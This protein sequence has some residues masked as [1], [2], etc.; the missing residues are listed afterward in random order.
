M[1]E[2]KNLFGE[3]INPAEILADDV[4][5]DKQ[6]SVEYE[7]RFNQII[8]KDFTEAD[9]NIFFILCAVAKIK[10]QGLSI[11]HLSK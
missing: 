10:E 7:N 3:V 4:V 5:Y 8:F 1:T 9:F 6:L 11:F 2:Q